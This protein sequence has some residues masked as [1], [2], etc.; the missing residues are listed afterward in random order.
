MDGNV[1]GAIIGLI[2]SGIIGLLGWTNRRNTEMM[3]K[4][5][6]SIDTIEQVVTEIRIEPPTRYVTKDELIN[7]RQTEERWHENINHQLIQIREEMSS[8]REWGHRR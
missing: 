2:G 4:I 5:T 1:M 7:H 6:S 8:L 3:A